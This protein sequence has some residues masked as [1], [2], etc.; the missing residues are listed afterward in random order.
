MTAR[1]A[2]AARITAE[3]ERRAREIPPEQYSLAR[4]PIL[5]MHQ[6]TVRACIRLLN[7]AGLFPM[8]GLR[9]ADIGCG[10]GGWLLEFVQWKAT[11]ANLAG[12]DLMPERVEA[13]RERVPG[14]DIRCGNASELPWPDASFDLVTQFL[15]FM[16]IFDPEL[17]RAIA[18]QMLRILKPGGTIL[19]FDPRVSN[20]R[21]PE[22]RGL[23]SGEIRALFPDCDVH[24]ES[25]LLA[26]PISRIFAEHAWPVAEALHSLPFLRTHYAGLIRKPG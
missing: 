8:T 23:R 10:F 3:Y 4:P 21:N 13:A 16:N 2:D 14:A 1:F 5:L 12:I 11:A 24:L 17:K 25:V 26:P 19:W 18:A 15:V 7:R 22:M 20:P 6:Q 9:I